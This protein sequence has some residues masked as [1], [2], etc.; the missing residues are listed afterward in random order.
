[1]EVKKQVRLIA[2]DEFPGQ[3]DWMF[4]RLHECLQFWIRESVTWRPHRLQVALEQA[5]EV[6]DRID[7]EEL[8]SW[9]EECQ[10]ALAC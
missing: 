3:G 7:A 10:V 4:V 8:L 5:W 2:D 6:G 9:P 1:M